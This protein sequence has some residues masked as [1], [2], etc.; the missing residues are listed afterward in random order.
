MT[1]KQE[2]STVTLQK[3]EIF[4]LFFKFYML[5]LLFMPLDMIPR[6]LQIGRR[7]WKLKKDNN[8]DINV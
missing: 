3:W 7:D 8:K 1:L 5:G 4:G 6:F 2:R